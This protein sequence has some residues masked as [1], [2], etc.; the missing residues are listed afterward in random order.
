[1][2]KQST[3]ILAVVLCAAATAAITVNGQEIDLQNIDKDRIEDGVQRYNANY[4]DQVPGL[5]QSLVG[6]ERVTVNVSADDENI[7]YGVVMDGMQID[8]VEQGGLDNATLVVYTSTDTVETIATADNPRDRAVTALRQE[9]IR[10]ET[11]GLFRTIK[12]GAV[13]TLITLF[14]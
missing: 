14:G 3:I 8:R 1:M 13:S 2:Q 10:Y 11:V 9:E 5:V 7:V 4:S 12:F 6:D